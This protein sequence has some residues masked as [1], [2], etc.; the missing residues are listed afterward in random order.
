MLS[1]C[2]TNENNKVLGYSASFLLVFLVGC[3]ESSVSEQSKLVEPDVVS[4]DAED[5]IITEQ[6]KILGE[7]DELGNEINVL[8]ARISASLQLDDVSGAKKDIVEFVAKATE[9]NSN[10]ER[11]KQLSDVDGSRS[12]FERD[13]LTVFDENEKIF[14]DDTEGWFSYIHERGG[15]E[16]QESLLTGLLK[17]LV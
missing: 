15:A 2:K 14:A 9:Y 11:F 6:N 17:L 3:E 5:S 1:E 4:V 7:N 10:S 12:T 16:A 8:I 13:V